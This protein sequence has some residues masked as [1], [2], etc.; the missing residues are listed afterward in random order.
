MS[1]FTVSLFGHRQIEDLREVEERLLKI[2][3]FFLQT[4]ENVVFLIGRNCE[5]DEYAASLIKRLRK[6][7]KL[8]NSELFLV[9]P[10]KVANIT[11][12]EKYYDGIII[13]E[14]MHRLYPKAAI[15]LRNQW[16]VERSDVIVFRIEKN[17]GCAYTAMKYAEKLCKEI[18]NI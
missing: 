10:Y 13:P 7:M 4:K 6:E 14:N 11:Y 8:D 1:A 15:K 18:I 3:Q 16:M 9:L 12:Y 17:N 5:F 2:I